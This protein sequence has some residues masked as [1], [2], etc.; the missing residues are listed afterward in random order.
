MFL[1]KR[2][3]KNRL[4]LL[5]I[6]IGA[7]GF[8]E[9]TGNREEALRQA[10]RYAQNHEYQ[11]AIEIY[12]EVITTNSGDI[13][14]RLGL[15]TVWAWQGSY[16]EAEKIY[17]QVLAEQPNVIDAKVGLIRTKAWSNK[18]SEALVD[19]RIIEEQN[20]SNL[21][22]MLLGAQIYSYSKLWDEAI[23]HYTRY[24]QVNS[25]NQEALRGLANVFYWKGDY[26]EA[27]RIL[28]KAKTF[29]AKNLDIIAMLADL[30]VQTAQREKA[31]LELSQRIALDS[32]DINAYKALGRIYQEEENP[33]KA[34][35]LYLKLLEVNSANIEILNKTADLYMLDKLWD[36]AQLYYSR[37]ASL[38][39]DNEIAIKA[40]LQIE[41]IKAP[42]YAMRYKSFY[43]LETDKA[44]DRVDNEVRLSELLLEG[45]WIYDPYTTI[46][47]KE[48][49]TQVKCEDKV[50]SSSKYNILRKSTQLGALHKISNKEWLRTAIETAFYEDKE[51]N[52]YTLVEPKVRIAGF[53]I[54]SKQNENSE[55]ILGASQETDYF[56]IIVTTNNKE[57]R[58]F[59]STSIF[60]S[61]DLLL[62]K[63]VS[64]L[65]GLAETY[66]GRWASYQLEHKARLKIWYFPELK[67]EYELQYRTNPDRTVSLFKHQWLDHLGEKT[68]YIVE[69]SL[70]FYSD[71]GKEY[72]LHSLLNHKF[73]DRFYSY[74]DTEG[75]LYQ[76]IASDTWY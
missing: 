28:E 62:N 10:S 46:I 45:Q 49:L 52:D 12:Q 19:Y 34:R 15:A 42:W 26:R 60:A 51:R 57:V 72:K 32:N 8:G 48:G 1:L 61:Y 38:A 23:S 13:E 14:A 29:D 71:L 59:E 25:A 11:K 56:T 70:G 31:M 58:L 33:D 35:E 55:L 75:G 9:V 68:L 69:S 66:N 17:Y 21:E 44:R 64:M 5:I 4:L 73:N 53:G 36:K 63:E 6:I 30:Y 20:S 50:N 24:L 7:F 39:S 40:L 16:A 37:V 2:I 74:V 22:I 3:I 41:R 47:A 54:W 43:A 67:G 76:Y 18:R 65:F 27:I